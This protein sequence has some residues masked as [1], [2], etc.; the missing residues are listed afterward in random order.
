MRNT[1]ERIIAVKERAKEMERQK[2]M[3]RSRITGISSAV[4]SLILVIVLSF[5]MP[6][7]I[8]TSSGGEY[9]YS[10]TAAGIFDRSVILAI[11]SLV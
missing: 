11:S 1:D 7:L 2:Q 5:A 10:G 4:A 8:L 9:A 6:G 3:R